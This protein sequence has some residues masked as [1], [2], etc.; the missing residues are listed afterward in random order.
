MPC[1]RVR[2]CK[3]GAIDGLERERERER[4]I[5]NKKRKEEQ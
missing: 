3:Q 1:R 2:E 4:D 5:T